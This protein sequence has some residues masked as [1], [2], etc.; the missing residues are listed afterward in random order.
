MTYSYSSTPLYVDE[1][2][3]IQFKFKAPPSW[4]FTQTITVQIGDLTQFWLISTISEDF[5]P[6]PFPLLPVDDAEVDTLYTYADGTRPNE[7]LITVSGLSSGTDAAISLSSNEVGDASKWSLRIDTDGDGTWDT[8]WIQPSGSTTVQNG[9]KIQIRGTTSS[10]SNRVLRISLVIGTSNEVWRIT[11]A[12]EP[13]NEPVPF[14]VFTDLEDLIVNKYAYSEVIRIQGMTTSGNIS[15]TGVG[16]WAVASVNNTTTNADGFDVLDGT[17]FSANQGTVSN[18]DYLQ[19][20]MLTAATGNTPRS[21]DLSIGDVIAGSTWTITTGANL[22]SSPDAFSFTDVNNAEADALIGSDEQPSGGITGLGTGVS[23]PVDVISTDATLVRVKKNNGSIGVFPTDVTNG[24]TLTIYL[25][26]STQFGDPKELQINVGSRTIP[27]WTVVTNS[28]PDTDAAF[29]PPS[30]KTNQIPDTFISSGPVTISGINLP[31]TI[32]SIGGY[33]ALISIDFDTPVEGPRTFDPALNTSFYLIIKSST[34]LSTP[35]FTQ[36]RVGTGSINNPFTWTV[37]TYAVV[38]PPS[39]NLGKWY[40][41]KTE[42]FDGYPIGTVIPILKEGATST[43]GTTDGALG[44][45]Y[46]GFIACEG[47]QLDAIQYWALFDVIGNTYGGTGDRQ[48]D[49]N[50]TATYSGVFNLPDYRNRRLCGVGIVDSS[51]G[52]SA[53]LPVS[54]SGKSINDVGAEGGFWYFDRV[55]AFGVQPLEQI[56]G[57]PANDTGLN[58]QFF[59]LGT[60]RLRGLETIVDDITFDI[61]GIVTAQIGPLQEVIVKPPEHD[62]AYLAAIVESDSITGNDPC[63]PWNG[64]TMFATGDPSVVDHGPV[65]Y[66]GGNSPTDAWTSWLGQLGVFQQELTLYYGNS[67]NFDQWVNDN[68]DTGYPVNEEINT[69][70][71][72]IGETDFGP[73]NEDSNR[74][75]DFLTWW[76]SP[77]SALDGQTLQSTGLTPNTGAGQN[78]ASAVVDTQPT[79]FLIDVYNPLGT[80]GTL[81]HSHYITE[82][83]IGNPST[84]FSGGNLAGLGNANAPEGSGLG[85]GITGGLQTFE[86]WQDRLVDQNLIEG[87]WTGRSVNQWAYRLT[88]SN[89]YWQDVNDSVTTDVTMQYASGQSGTGTGM[90]L[91][92]T[93][94]PWPTT[95][96][97][98]NPLGDTRVRINQ[99]VSPGQNY[100]AGEEL[101]FP[102]WNTEFGGSFFRVTAVSPAGTGGAAGSL[103]VSFSQNDIFMDMTEGQFKFSSNFQKPTPDITM[104]PQRQVPIVNPFHKTKY[105]IKAY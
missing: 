37:T 56:Q 75:V 85:G 3:Y 23:V 52:G 102:L 49:I 68:L 46:A 59:S 29:L 40:S 30:D 100:L 63:I 1:G 5:T 90:I 84:D 104:R 91:N 18:G 50:G 19:I 9:A 67:F 57:P 94:T 70:W 76:I 53:F 34:Q 33:N 43:Y 44:S 60:V 36:I 74:V 39:T 98:P 58:S 83:I 105:M 20:R 69:N 21:T 27:T 66:G 31:V 14:P 55:D 11:N 92:I 38:P 7:S 6:D 71:L 73:L 61:Q 12:P 86:L 89:T 41:K 8:G 81:T 16:E 42:K 87:A 82:S 72:G 24:D 88:G 99:I 97:T 64:R 48:L 103:Q 26:S 54:T 10:F 101:T 47:Q 79:K 25:Q 62:H 45:R 15:L 95:A 35:E 4:D 96:Q 32:E 22:S 80:A 51:R 17:T 77:V 2:D 28:G 78:A 65:K 13:L 93:L